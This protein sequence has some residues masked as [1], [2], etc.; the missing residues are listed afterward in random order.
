MMS[1]NHD[2]M[3]HLSLIQ[4]KVTNYQN[5]HQ[6]GQFNPSMQLFKNKDTQ[7]QEKQF[8]LRGGSLLNLPIKPMLF[9]TS[10][11]QVEANFELK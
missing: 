4:S 5:A 3:S 9:N 6:S 8:T 10:K 11:S 7:L 1:S 2:K